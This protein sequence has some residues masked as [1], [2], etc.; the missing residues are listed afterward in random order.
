MLRSRNGPSYIHS[1]C[2][3]NRA[4]R[5]FPSPIRPL[6]RFV[7]SGDSHDDDDDDVLSIKHS[8]RYLSVRFAEAPSRVYEFS[9]TDVVNFE[10]SH[11]EPTTSRLDIGRGLGT[12]TARCFFTVNVPGRATVHRP[13]RLTPEEIVEGGG[14]TEV[15][16]TRFLASHPL[17]SY[18][19]G[20]TIKVYRNSL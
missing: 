1:K 7:R 19:A 18:V 2:I 16:Y 4:A 20:G 9:L 11:R 13:I 10:R 17:R 8:T 12:F 6:F 14:G 5:T 15:R 3:V